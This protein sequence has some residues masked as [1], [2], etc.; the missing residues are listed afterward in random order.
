MKKRDA[1]FMS[2]TVNKLGPGED[3]LHPFPT[4]TF[5][6]EATDQVNGRFDRMSSESVAEVDDSVM[7]IKRQR[8]NSGFKN[9]CDIDSM[10]RRHARGLSFRET[11]VTPSPRRRSETA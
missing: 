1:E 2:G 9:L 4:V 8:P 6:I 11:R 3:P 7:L 10:A 5:M